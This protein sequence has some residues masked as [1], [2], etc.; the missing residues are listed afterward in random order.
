LNTRNIYKRSSSNCYVA[1]L[2][3]TNNT[4]LDDLTVGYDVG[5][6]DLAGSLRPLDENTRLGYDRYGP[7]CAGTGYAVLNNYC[8]S[9]NARRGHKARS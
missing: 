8:V 2:P 3:G 9:I 7:N 4:V 6:A 5:L 1:H